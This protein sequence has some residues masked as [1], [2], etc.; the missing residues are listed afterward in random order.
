LSAVHRIA[1]NWMRYAE[2]AAIAVILGL[3]MSSSAS[4]VHDTIFLSTEFLLSWNTAIAVICNTA[5]V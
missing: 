1:E 2:P 4:V 3:F 5:V